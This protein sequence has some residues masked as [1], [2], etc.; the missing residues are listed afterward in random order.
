MQLST[1]LTLGLIFTVYT[2]TQT[3]EYEEW[4]GQVTMNISFLNKHMFMSD[5]KTNLTA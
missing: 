3:V 5:M 2:N 4:V 1:K